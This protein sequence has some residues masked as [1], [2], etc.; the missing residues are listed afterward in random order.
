[1]RCTVIVRRSWCCTTTILAAILSANSCFSTHMVLYN[2]L[3]WACQGASLFLSPFQGHGGR[4]NS[5]VK[6]ASVKG[7]AFLFPEKHNCLSFIPSLETKEM[8]KY[9]KR[10]AKIHWCS[11]QENSKCNIQFSGAGTFPFCE[12]WLSFQTQYYCFV[13]ENSCTVP[14]P[15]HFYLIK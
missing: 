2:P 9:C 3:G 11:E 10:T 8:K 12:S 15:L 1:M 6:Q 14:N 4:L 13:F 7:W 5:S